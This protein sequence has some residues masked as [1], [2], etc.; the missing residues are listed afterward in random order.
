MLTSRHMRCL[1]NK[2]VCECHK[3]HISSMDIWWAGIDK[4]EEAVR[5]IKLLVLL[6]VTS[7]VTDN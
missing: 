2:I 4:E 7:K 5:L 1:L 6:I 3:I